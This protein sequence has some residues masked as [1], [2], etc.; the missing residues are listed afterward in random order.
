[1]S[2]EPDLTVS[3]FARHFQIEAAAVLVAILRDSNASPSSR[4]AAAERILHFAVG[5]PGTG[6][7]I[8]VDDLERM[9]NQQRWDLLKALVSYYA[10]SEFTELV[11]QSVDA[12]VEQQTK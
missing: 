3:Q 12:A 4:T 1:M 5:R 10:P 11:Q 7:P 8:K 6:A 2:T 9:S